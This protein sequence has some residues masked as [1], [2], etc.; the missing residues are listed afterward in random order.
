MKPSFPDFPKQE[1]EHRYARARAMMAEQDIDALFITE[2]LNYAYLSGHRSCQNPI[3]KI[4]SYMFILPK[5]DEPTLIT[6][7]FEVAQVEE[8][9]Y[10]DRIKTIGGL[11]GHPEFIIDTLMSLGLG[12]ARVGAELGREQYLG[13]NVLSLRQIM[14][15]LS[16]AEFV[17]AAQ[18]LLDLRVVKTPLEIEYCR[19]SAEINAQAQ[20]HTFENIR[21]GMTENEVANV[22]RA[23]L[24]ETGA[25]DLTLLCVVSGATPSTGIV[26]LPTDRVLQKGETVGLDVGIT[27]KGYCSDLARTASVGA[28]SEELS[29]FYGWVM[30]LRRSCD[31]KLRAGN[32]AADVIAVCDEYLAAREM[33]TMGVGR[34]GH[35]VGVETTEYPSLA[36]FEKVPFK[37]GMVFAC[38]PNFANHFGFINAEDNW[39]IT[40]GEPDLLSDPMAKLEI[41]VVDG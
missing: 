31:A 1:F 34:V 16:E 5:D 24:F 11:T 23:R 4:R 22:L 19:R 39:A 12:K 28:P 26:L 3:D 10:I 35:G 2:K 38:N 30:S 7:P 27:Y 32:S 40:D 8:T 20:V 14:D 21:A 29:E 18:I 6:M 9:T 17:D 41:P 15:G 37:N 33:K 25:E 13:T 36:A